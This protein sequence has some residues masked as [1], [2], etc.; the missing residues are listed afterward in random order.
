MCI[1]D[2]INGVGE[3]IY[4][5]EGN[6]N[7]ILTFLYDN[8]YYKEPPG[9]W[10]YEPA[11]YS[12]TGPAKSMASVEGWNSP[13]PIFASVRKTD[14]PHTPGC[15]HCG[16]WGHPGYSPCPVDENGIRYV[17][18][19]CRADFSNCAAIPNNTSGLNLRPL[20]V[21]PAQRSD[22][23]T[24]PITAS[25]YGNYAWLPYVEYLGAEN[26]VRLLGALEVQ[27]RHR[28][29][30]SNIGQ[31]DWGYAVKFVTDERFRSMTLSINDHTDYV[32][33]YPNPTTSILTIDGGKDYQIKVYDLL[34]NKVLETQGNSINMEHLSTATYIVKAT[35][36]S[37]N[38]ELT[39]KVVKN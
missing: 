16:P 14:T 37:N 1:R 25:L 9:P 33:I 26:K 13:N 7:G 24:T 20:G 8:G 31:L 30:N 39:Y 10:H 4:P 34:G 3:N 38:E 35:D 32:T 19:I 29:V 27:Y 17:S 6:V 18:E 11:T 22:A 23:T 36:K 28:Y 2:S 15:N 21:I 12:G 5:N